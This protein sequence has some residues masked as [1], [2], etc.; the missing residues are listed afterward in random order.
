[1]EDLPKSYEP[2]EHEEEIYRLWETSGFFNP[3]SLPDAEKRK[4]F[5]IMMAPPNITGHIHVGHALENVAS[6]VLIRRKRMEGFKTLLLPG[7]DHAGIAGQYAVEKEIK[8]EGKTRQS[9]GREKFL[10]RVW[11]YMREIGSNIDQELKRLGISVDWSRSRF[12]MDES[13]Q[14]AVEQVFLRYHKKG[15]IYR[16]KRVVNWCP[17]CY[18]TISDLE[19]EYTEEKGSLYHIIY[20]P[21]ELAT[22]RPE[23][24]LGD[25]A[26]AVN[27]NDS[28]YTQYVGAEIKIQSVDPSVPRTKAPRTK[29]ITIRV[30]ADEAAD[31]QFGTGVIKVTP[32]HDLADFGIWERHQE[33]PIIKIIGEDG[34]MNENAGVR[35]AGLTVLE[36][37]EQMVKDLTALGLMPKVEEYEHAVARCGRCESVIEPLLSDQWFIAMKKLSEKAMA[38]I[39]KNRVTFVPQNRKDLML[40]WAENVRDWNISRQ[41]WWGHRIPAWYCACTEKT[42]WHIGLTPPT[43]KCKKC[44]KPWQQTTDVLDTWFSSALWPFVTLGWPD[45][46]EDLKT[47]YPTAL[48]SSAREIFFLW[49]FRMLFSGLEF[50]GDI[51]FK[52]IYTHPTILDSKGRKMSKSKGNVVDPMKL[53]ET[54]GIDAAR[55]GLLWQA[56]STQDIHWSEDPLRAGKKFLNK[57]W[58]SS[59]FILARAGADTREPKRPRSTRPHVKKILSALDATS[60]SVG[61]SIEN[62]EFGVALHTLYDFYWH[63]FCDTF[64]EETKK[65]SSAETTNAL[66]YVLAESLKLMHPFI[67]FVTEHI[68]A[69]LPSGHKRLLIVEPL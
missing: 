12:T 49:I 24:K 59:R 3:D 60:K 30:V 17:R 46:T 18:T 67:P 48:I 52:T 55:F 33:I 13:Y 16:G 10:E 44:K 61:A 20:G 64:I 31:P 37:R 4:P 29:E 14:H 43:E 68:W 11:E 26:L 53:V 39:K 22:A 23:T 62:F 1:M 34:R 21:V 56:M 19:V 66:L 5:S 38:A 42:E 58:N 28:R 69:L 6:D 45:E 25:T 47:Y 35:F 15:L 57:I 9:L 40:N 54:Y 7:K 36:A 32:A 50:V 41:L 27:P 8:K 63:D 2:K 65:D 51:P